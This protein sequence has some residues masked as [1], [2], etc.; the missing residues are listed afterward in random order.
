MLDRRDLP[1]L[2]AGAPIQIRQAS[3]RCLT[4]RRD[5]AVAA[6][7]LLEAAGPFAGSPNSS[8][9]PSEG[10]K[11]GGADAA[12]HKPY[13]PVRKLPTMPE[14]P[15]FIGGRTRT[16]T[17]DPLIKS[18]RLLVCLQ[19]VAS[20]RAEIEAAKINGLN[21]NCK[22]S[23]VC[24]QIGRIRSLP[25]GTTASLPVVGTPATKAGPKS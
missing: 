21:R 22:T 18:L 16:R 14:I 12:F 11:A 5:P 25:R 17:W 13:V 3:A 8:G 7:P 2:V 10:G 20:K 6:S 23:F 9:D 19:G 1:S 15:D 4:V 24:N